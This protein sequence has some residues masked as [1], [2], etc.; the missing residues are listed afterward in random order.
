MKSRTKLTIRQIR[1][2]NAF[3]DNLLKYTESPELVHLYESA[4]I[5]WVKIGQTVL[6][7]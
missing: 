3:L 5:N 1:S 4:K 7:G 2:I 6:K